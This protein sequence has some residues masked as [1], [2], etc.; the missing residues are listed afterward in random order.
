MATA[1]SVLLAGMRSDQPCLSKIPTPVQS[2]L[3]GGFVS[4]LPDLD[5]PAINFIVVDKSGDLRIVSLSSRAE[6]LWRQRNLVFLTV[7][8]PDYCKCDIG[9]RLLWRSR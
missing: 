2:V 6:G 7:W 3:Q 1:T 9:L 4:F 8:H 5:L